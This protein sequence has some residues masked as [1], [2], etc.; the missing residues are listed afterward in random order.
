MVDDGVFVLAYGGCSVCG[1]NW[2]VGV[3][4]S[5]GGVIDGVFVVAYGWLVSKVMGR[6]VII[7]GVFAVAYGELVCWWP[8]RGS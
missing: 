3:G 1:G 5:L 7:V 4:W 8:T 6:L 2:L